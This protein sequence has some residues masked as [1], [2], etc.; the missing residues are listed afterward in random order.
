[1]G[2]ILSEPGALRAGSNIAVQPR[3]NR[4]VDDA[5]PLVSV[6]IPSYQAA[7]HIRA[8]LRALVTQETDLP[9]EIIVV[10]SSTDETAGIVER[11]FPQIRLLRQPERC[12]VGAA[13]NIGVA[14]ARGGVILFIDTDAIPCPTWLDQMARGI[15]DDNADAVGGAMSNGTPWSVS[16][17][18]GFYL[19]FFRFVGGGRRHRA[20]RH[21]VGGNSGFRR[22][23]LNRTTYADH[24]VGEDMLFSSRLA[25][26]GKKL[27]FLERASVRHMNRTGFRNVLSYQRKLGGGAYFYR[28]QDSPEQLRTFRAIP[29]LVFLLPFAVMLWIGVNLLHRRT[30]GDFLRF[31]L[32]L[33][34]CFTGNMSWARGFYDALKEANRSRP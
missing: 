11:E 2:R 32:I 20:A 4:A 21:L 27:V 12:Q 24:S 19:E 18:A 10:D 1:M 33:P 7:R 13:R 31:V 29:A 6:V 5:S 25:R 9:H 26:Q 3:E 30:I 34:V 23:I 14:A 22:E 8:T 28:S 17:S 15:R 16:G